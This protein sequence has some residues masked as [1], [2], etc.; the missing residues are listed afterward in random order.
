MSFLLK[1]EAIFCI[2]ITVGE[3]WSFSAMVAWKHRLTNT[4]KHQKKMPVVLSLLTYLTGR[5]WGLVAAS[6]SQ[7]H[8]ESLLAVLYLS[9]GWQNYAGADCAGL[10]PEIH[11]EAMYVCRQIVN[12][13][14]YLWNMYLLQLQAQI[15]S[16]KCS[17]P[18]N[19]C[20][21]SNL[22][23]TISVSRAF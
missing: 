6:L 7:S 22:C 15:F 18:V 14:C 12:Q 20:L 23:V 10:D 11:L 13:D 9:A 8:L 21:S 3:E 5:L 1:H 17:S 4:F 19:L 16:R 2:L